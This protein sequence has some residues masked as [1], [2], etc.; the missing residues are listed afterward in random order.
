M[1]IKRL[2]IVCLP[3]RG[4]LNPA[5]TLGRHLVQRGYEVVCINLYMA[6][7]FIAK[8]GLEFVPIDS[9]E[10]LAAVELQKPG[11]SHTIQSTKTYMQRVF[12]NMP[13]ALHKARV[14]ALLV[15]Q[16][17]L[18]TGSVA[19]LL[20]IPFVTT[21]FF[22]PLYLRDDMPPSI[23]DWGPTQNET[24]RNRNRRGNAFF[25][26]MVAPL[27][28]MI[29]EQRHRWQLSELH[30]FND[31]C[32]PLGIVTQLPE[33]LEFPV[34]EKLDCLHYTGSFNDG[35]RKDIVAFPWKRLD[36]RPIIY[37]S[38]GTVRANSPAAFNIIARACA[39]L[40][41]QVVLSLGGML[42]TPDE[43]GALPENV[44]V[45]HYVPQD[46]LLKQAS[47]MVTHAGLNTTL[48]ALSHGVPLVAIPITDD[49]PGVAARVRWRGV[50]TVLPFRD[51]SEACLKEKIEEVIT[52]PCYREAA[53]EICA[54]LAQIDGVEMALNKIEQ[55]LSG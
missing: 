7:G 50:G 35:R 39:S 27:M 47:L 55:L 11:R 37:A 45:A 14:D 28:S 19:E 31:I 3:S 13:D 23:F 16:G 40:K 18:A 9:S 26:R 33:A 12:K 25:R 53:K 54:I 30:D 46:E 29:N 48:D 20:G 44:I 6:R 5:T 38:L 15:D 32:S 21:S 22:P 17:D 36:G 1:H 24:D 8:A 41:H 34:A 2:G 51:L 10:N 42:L 52:R 49:Q 4:H 43:M